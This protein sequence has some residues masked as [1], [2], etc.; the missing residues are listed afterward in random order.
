MMVETKLSQMFVTDAHIF[1]HCQ[2]HKA[3]TTVHLVNMMCI[4][5]FFLHLWTNVNICKELA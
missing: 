1:K 5:L 2:S 4:H 3:I